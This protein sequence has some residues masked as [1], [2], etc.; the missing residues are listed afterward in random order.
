M[1][2]SPRPASGRRTARF[3][4]PTAPIRL[5]GVRRGWPGAR[6]ARI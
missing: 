2:A 3:P 6:R 4:P 5:P 1:P